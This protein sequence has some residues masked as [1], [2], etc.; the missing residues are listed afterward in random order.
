MGDLGK[1]MGI[2]YGDA[3]VGVALSNPEKQIAFGREM[4]LNKSKNAVIYRIKQIIEEDNVEL[5]ILGL[6]FSM[7]GEDTAQTTNVRKFGTLLSKAV[8]TSIVYQD[9][10]LT[11]YE[12][13]GILTS[14]GVSGRNKKK[15][16]DIIAASLILQNYLDL[17]GEKGRK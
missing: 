4:I 1:I 15:E 8:K 7:E 6:P 13:N 12:S 11:T 10:R 5:I 2:D 9:E 3:R 14:I 17:K 16:K